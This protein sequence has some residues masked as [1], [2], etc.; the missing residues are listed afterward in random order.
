[1]LVLILQPAMLVL[2]VVLADLVAPEPAESAEAV[3]EEDRI[4]STTNEQ[5]L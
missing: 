3:V 1:M 5:F 4:I 2:L